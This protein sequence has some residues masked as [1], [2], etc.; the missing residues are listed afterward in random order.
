VDTKTRE[1]GSV[2][3]EQ[4]Y[5]VLFVGL[6]CHIN[7]RGR[8]DRLILWPDGSNPSSMVTPHY[9]YIA[10]DPD[11]IEYKEGWYPSNE[12]QE[13]LMET[14][15]FRLPKCRIDM[16]GAD[17]SKGIDITAHDQFLTKLDAID[18]TAQINL[19]NVNAVAQMTVSS[20]TF[21]ALR[22]EGRAEG[23]KVDAAV[24]THL[25]VPHGG[26]ITVTVYPEAERPRKL[27]L[28]PG[29][30]VAVA[31]IAFPDEGTGVEHFS[32]YGQLTPSRT[33]RGTA[34]L[35]PNTVPLLKTDHQLFSLG[36]AITDGS[37]ECGPT[38]C[39]S[40]GGPP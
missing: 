13:D 34:N 8:P 7:K 14:G 30:E 10:V 18:D 16:S 2:R 5:D 20:G 6:A 23:T 19:S 17:T 12:S 35:I 38:A 36:I 4:G 40:Q 15:L 1:T 26:P 28:K 31:N 29:T 39:C 24:V 37:A 3:E 33:L 32:I 27:V 9:A 21:T 11:M 25:R 22:T